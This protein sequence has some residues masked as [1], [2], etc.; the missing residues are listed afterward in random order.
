[1]VAVVNIQEN[2]IREASL[3]PA[4]E[5]QQFTGCCLVTITPSGIYSSLAAFIVRKRMI[6]IHMSHSLNS[7]KGFFS[8][9][10]QGSII[11]F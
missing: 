8:G 5:T 4:A 11:G 1:M 3:R 6:Y 10:I 7:L 9:I 2:M